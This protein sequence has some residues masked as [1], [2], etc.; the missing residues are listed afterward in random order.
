MYPSIKERVGFKL[1]IPFIIK[2][3]GWIFNSCWKNTSLIMNSIY[4]NFK[5]P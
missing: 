2:Q 1:K 5:D 3:K 4:D